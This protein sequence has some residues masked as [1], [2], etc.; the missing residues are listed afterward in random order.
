MESKDE[1][2]TLNE[3]DVEAFNRNLEGMLTMDTGEVLAVIA[4]ELSV[5]NLILRDLCEAIKT[6][7]APAG[8]PWTSS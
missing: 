8:T 4:S 1:S 6:Y 5:T 2:K 7:P 3:K